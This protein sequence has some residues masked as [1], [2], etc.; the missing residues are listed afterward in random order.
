MRLIRPWFFTSLLFPRAIF[1]MKTGEKQICLTFDDG[2]NPETT[3]EILRILKEHNVRA[4][5]FC[6]GDAAERYPDLM[7]EIISEG[8]MTGNHGYSHLDGWKTPADMYADDVERA[9]LFVPSSFF[10]PPYGRLTVKQDKTLL[11]KY[12]IVFW[13]LMPYDFDAEFG[14]ENS[15][16]VLK[17]KIRPGSVIVLHDSPNSSVIS[18]LS[19]FIVFAFRRGFSFVL[20]ADNSGI[21]T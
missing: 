2:P 13:D 9:S 14:P 7:Q 10:R 18:F 17:K 11:K 1:R 8:H 19:E 12:K 20:P 4:L 16:R 6:R 21:K 5:F 15:L 3:P